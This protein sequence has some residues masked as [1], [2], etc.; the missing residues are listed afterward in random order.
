MT[1]VLIVDDD[2]DIVRI[3]SI[4]LRLSGFDVRIAYDGQAALEAVQAFDPDVALLDIGLPGLDGF[5]LAH[6]LR[7]RHGPALLL[8]AITGYGDEQSRKKA[9]AAGFDHHFTKPVDLVMLESLL[10]QQ[11]VAD[12]TPGRPAR[13]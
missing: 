10:P 1:R 6:R 7:E 5:T 3:S 12:P 2:T 13:R 4:L 8:I 9:R 11:R